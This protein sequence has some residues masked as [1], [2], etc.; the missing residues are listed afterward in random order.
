[1]LFSVYK[2][3]DV[4]GTK[5]SGY[6]HQLTNKIKQTHIQIKKYSLHVVNNVQCVGTVHPTV[7]TMVSNKGIK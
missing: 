2:H 4:K 7:F 5:R 6:K 1:M 3:K